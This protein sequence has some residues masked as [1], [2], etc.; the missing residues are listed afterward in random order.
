MATPKPY[1]SL[2]NAVVFTAQLNDVLV[3]AVSLRM[4][5]DVPGNIVAL[6]YGQN[7]NVQAVH[8]FLWLADY[9]TFLYQ[10][11]AAAPVVTDV[12]PPAGGMTWR[13][14]FIHPDVHVA[15]GHHFTV[16][17][18]SPGGCVWYVPGALAAAPFVNGHL[19]APQDGGTNNTSNGSHS[20]RSWFAATTWGPG[21]MPALDVLFLPD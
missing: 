19:S 18:C 8:T 2:L 17:L 7:A 15:A 5:S 20:Q 4:V 3:G 16:Q 21:H 12:L 6:R 14:S 9:D 11:I 1:I 13:T 10:P